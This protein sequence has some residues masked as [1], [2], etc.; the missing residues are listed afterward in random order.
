MNEIAEIQNWFQS[1]CDGDWEHGCGIR[2]ES[3]DN[4]G[5][6]IEIELNGTNLENAVFIPVERNVSPSLPERETDWYTCKVEESKFKG[7]GGPQH[8]KTILRMF[9]EWQK[10]LTANNT[11]VPT[12]A[13]RSGGTV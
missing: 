7:Y 13:K 12:V 8:L 9:L 2:I 3:L 5:W 1:Q 10:D 6:K 4:P 11:L